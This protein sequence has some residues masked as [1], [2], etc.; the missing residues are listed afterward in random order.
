MS[1]DS[2]SLFSDRTRHARKLLVVDFGFLGDSV[3]LVPTLWE[4]QRHHPKAELHVLTT[5]VGGEVLRM[6][7]CVDTVWD[8]EL[9]PDRRTKREQLRIFR[10][11]RREGFDAA[12]N[13]SGSDRTVFWTWFSGARE[14]AAAAWGKHHFWTRW[15]IPH[16]VDQQD[17][18][19]PVARQ[20]QRVLTALGFDCAPLRYDLTPDHGAEQ[21]AESL[22]ARGSIHLSVNAAKPLKEWPLEHSVSLARGL[23]AHSGEICIVASGSDREREQERLH[24]LSDAVDHPNLRLLPADLSIP[25]LTA[26]L[27]RCSLHIGPDSGVMNLAA[28]VDVPTI[29]FFRNQAGYKSWLPMGDSHQAFVGACHCVDHQDAPCL[30]SG[31]ADCL[32]AI[33]PD[34]ALEAALQ[35]RRQQRS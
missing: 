16:L 27:Q 34:M 18:E 23:L 28:A 5:R 17:P 11:L 32:A 24:R 26:V 6:A 7:R 14:R 12:F 20:R 25:E 2:R 29:S 8:L 31:Q 33:T 21:R 35:R 10:G 22:V 19:L 30:S 9:M 1:S 15:L 3:Q 4:L 13:F